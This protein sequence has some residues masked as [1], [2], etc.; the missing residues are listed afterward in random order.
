MDYLPYLGNSS[1]FRFSVG[2]YNESDSLTI[3]DTL[4]ITLEYESLNVEATRDTNTTTITLMVTYTNPL[5]A[6]MTGVIVS[7]SGP[8]NT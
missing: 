6:L 4:L 2:A 1:V 7:V 5:S 3:H 8:D